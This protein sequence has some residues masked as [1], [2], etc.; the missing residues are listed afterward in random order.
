MGESSAHRAGGEGGA[1]TSVASWVFAEVGAALAGGVGV[2]ALRPSSI[3][4]NLNSFDNGEPERV[5]YRRTGSRSTAANPSAFDNGEP[6]CVR[7][8]RT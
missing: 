1:G 3:T 5:R 7:Y 4:A 8:R 2:T 6:E